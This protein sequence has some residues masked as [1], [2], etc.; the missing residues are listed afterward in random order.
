MVL[1]ENLCE[2]AFIDVSV[3]LDISY[4]L[5]IGKGNQEFLH[6]GS[7]IHECANLALVCFRECCTKSSNS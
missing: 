6:L 7:E 3:P 5:S 1:F 4:I 2:A